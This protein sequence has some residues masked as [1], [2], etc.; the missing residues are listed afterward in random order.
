MV[1]LE[2]LSAL[3]R[4]DEV[5]DKLS[6]LFWNLLDRWYWRRKPAARNSGGHVVAVSWI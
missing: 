3:R 4:F 1:L 5:V 2:Y 6:H